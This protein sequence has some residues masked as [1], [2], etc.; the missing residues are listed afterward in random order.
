M[1][2]P[3][4]PRFPRA[5]LVLLVLLGAGMGESEA[6]PAP[7]QHGARLQD[8]TPSP[9]FANYRRQRASRSLQGAGRYMDRRGT[10]EAQN[11]LEE[12][13]DLRGSTRLA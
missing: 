8:P 4:P 5:L 1:S 6:R 12:D 3:A 9:E 13:D 10:R 11:I 2:I 7:G